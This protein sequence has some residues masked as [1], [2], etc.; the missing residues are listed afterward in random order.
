M[1]KMSKV[2]IIIALSMLA[3][4]FVIMFQ[5]LGGPPVVVPRSAL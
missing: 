3:A 2:V 4:L 1:S 5:G